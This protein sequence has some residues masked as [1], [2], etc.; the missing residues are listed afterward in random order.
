M[1]LDANIYT[2]ITSLDDALDKLFK[3]LD[4]AR[5]SSGQEQLPQAMACPTGQAEG[6]VLCAPVIMTAKLIGDRHR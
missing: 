2:E 3:A 6:S 4:A 1:T 5:E